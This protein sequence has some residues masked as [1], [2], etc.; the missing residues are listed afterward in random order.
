MDDRALLKDKSM[1]LCRPNVGRPSG[2]RA[3]DAAPRLYL[4][5]FAK[6][7]LDKFCQRRSQLSNDVDDVAGVLG[8]VVL[9]Q[10]A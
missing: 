7:K 2:F 9:W 1:S 5:F 6:H 8:V 3:E 4:D 10:K